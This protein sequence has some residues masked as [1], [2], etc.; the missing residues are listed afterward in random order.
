VGN[1]LPEWIEELAENWRAAARTETERA[2]WNEQ[3]KE[4]K[5]SFEKER[6]DN[7]RIR[8]QLL[9]ESRKAVA[10]SAHASLAARHA[11]ELIAE[12]AVLSGARD[13]ARDEAIA[14]ARHASGAANEAQKSVAEV[15]SRA[16][17]AASDQNEILEETRRAAE[18]TRAAQDEIAQVATDLRAGLEQVADEARSE[19]AMKIG[20]ALSA[21]EQGLRL[22]DDSVGHATKTTADVAASGT[23]HI[24]AAI[25]Q[26]RADLKETV[27]QSRSEAARIASSEAQARVRQ[28]RAEITEAVTEGRN[29]LDVFTDRVV[30]KVDAAAQEAQATAFVATQQ[31]VVVG[32]Q[33][34]ESIESTADRALGSVERVIDISEQA[35]SSVRAAVAESTSVAERA[36]LEAQERIATLVSEAVGRAT[37]ETSR[38]KSDARAEIHDVVEA[39]RVACFDAVLQTRKESNIATDDVRAAVASA[40]EAIGLEIVSAVDSVGELVSDAQERLDEKSQSTLSDIALSSDRAER[41]AAKAARES[42]AAAAQE[43]VEIARR[44]IEAGRNTIQSTLIDAIERIAETAD[45]KREAVL[46]MVA[47]VGDE[48][49]E[50][51]EARA[52]QTEAAAEKAT[53]EASAGAVA[54]DAQREAARSAARSADAADAALEAA[55][56][57]AEARIAQEQAALAA[58]SSAR[59]SSETAEAA[60]VALERSIEQI[61]GALA[62]REK[63]LSSFEEARTLIE[64]TLAKMDYTLGEM[65]DM[66]ARF[67]VAQAQVLEEQNATLSETQVAARAAQG[68]ARAAQASS[69]GAQKDATRALRAV[70]AFAEKDEGENRVI[71]LDG[72]G[73]DEPNLNGEIMTPWDELADGEIPIEEL[74]VAADGNGDLDHPDL[75]GEGEP[76]L[77]ERILT[78]LRPEKEDTPPE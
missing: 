63:A 37:D 39:A 54:F 69:V 43:H 28:A 16:T 19:V 42:A 51:V 34:K 25:D 72:N 2:F 14:A 13:K 47:D 61:E 53:K 32:E 66:I 40:R 24:V 11:E 77:L 20:A 45:A 46:S 71:R 9:E 6:S 26:A 23:K 1:Q 59:S 70:V 38:L 10:Q 76:P 30:K 68:A 78:K 44:D 52:L 74:W 67:G 5:A 31:A 50:R 12:N 56:K 27:V 60:R 3:L 7:E 64:A 55:Q 58:E 18:A 22:V 4:L 75:Y 36:A 49:T 41:L 8:R 33:L 21:L 48:I 65:T 62:D 15:K 35:E 29:N 57:E 17:R 73:H